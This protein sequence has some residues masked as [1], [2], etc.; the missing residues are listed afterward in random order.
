MSTPDFLNRTRTARRVLVIDQGFL[1]D[2]LHL[3]PALWEIR[4]H[5]P[6]AALEVVTTP[7]A[8]E[9]LALARCADRL[10]PL[11]L[12]PERRSLREQLRLLHALRRE[13]FEV[14]FNLNAADRSILLTGLCGARWRLGLTGGRWHFWY[15]WCIPHWLPEPDPDLPVFEHHRQ[16]LM[17]AGFV[18]GEPRFGLEV[19]PDA[20]D[21]AAAWGSPSTVHLSLNSA[22]PLKE[23]PVRHYAQLVAQVWAARPATAFLL[24]G[25]RSAR[26]QRRLDAFFTLVADPRARRLPPGLSLAQ[27]AAVLQGCH[28][29]VGPDSGVI[30]LAAALGVPTVSL[31]RQRGGYRAWLPVGPHHQH[32]L[33]PCTCVHDHGSRCAVL[34]EP[35]CLVRVAPEAVSGQVLRALACGGRQTR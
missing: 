5:Y 32:L 34:G 19:P 24:S 13:R 3:L 27:L 30:H 18:L 26:E 10:R 2:A 6:R 16:A 7:V 23:W 17:A 29:H 15:R 20:R 21:W 25:T 12:M 11:E 9:L 31:F 8:C 35:E 28:L 33:A 4:R 1:G 14:A 22:N